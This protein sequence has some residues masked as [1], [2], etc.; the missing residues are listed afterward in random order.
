MALLK[1]ARKHWK[2]ILAVIYLISPIDIIPDVLIPFG[3][4]EDAI[5]L[6]MAV[7]E[8][9]SKKRKKKGKIIDGEIVE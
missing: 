6:L 5:L 1:F 4:T 3:Y 8:Y 9:Y 2:L 7:L